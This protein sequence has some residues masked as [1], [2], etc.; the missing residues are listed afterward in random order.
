MRQIVIDQ[1]GTQATLE[2][3]QALVNYIAKHRSLPVD[4]ITDNEI[5]KFFA[6]AAGQAFDRAVTE[7]VASDG[8][9][10]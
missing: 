5:I 4:L 10:S 9:A 6:D 3:T 2:V 7:Y 1:A 8:K